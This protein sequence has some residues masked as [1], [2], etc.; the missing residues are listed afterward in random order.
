MKKLHQ[1]YEEIF[2]PKVSLIIQNTSIGSTDLKKMLFLQNFV[3]CFDLN[4]KPYFC[5]PIKKFC[6]LEKAQE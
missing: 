6:L 2:L 4:S 3:K 5:Y 1:F